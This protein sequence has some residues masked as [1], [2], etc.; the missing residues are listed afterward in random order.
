MVKSAVGCAWLL[1]GITK[2]AAWKGG[3]QISKKEQEDARPMDRCEENKKALAWHWQCDEDEQSLNEKP[4]K[5][6]ELKK[7]EDALPRLGESDLEKASRI[8]KAKT[9]MG[10]DGFHPKGSLGLDKRDN[11][12]RVEFLEKVEQSGKWPQQACTTMFLLIPKNVT[13]ERPIAFLR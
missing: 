6:E 9:G 4:W 7:E 10:C 2:S 8:Y 1:H 3:V 11:R 13:S 12:G 5:N